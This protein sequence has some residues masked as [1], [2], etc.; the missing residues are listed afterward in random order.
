MGRYGKAQQL[1]AI[2]NKQE[3]YNQYWLILFAYLSLLI[4]KASKN[5]YKS[6]LKLKKKT[7]ENSRKIRAYLEEH[8]TD[9]YIQAWKEACKIMGKHIP[10]PSEDEI[11]N[12][13]NETWVGSFNFKQ[14][15]ARNTNNFLNKLKDLDKDEKLSDEERLVLK[16][17]LVK[18]YRYTVYR[19]TRTETARIINTASLRAYQEAGVNYVEW[20]TADDEKVCPICGARER[21]VYQVSL[22]PNC[23]DHPNCRCV[24]IPY[25]YYGGLD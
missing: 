13:V 12:I 7:L 25:K 19:L 10:L 9:T 20:V 1:W 23:P 15:Q 24:L 21:K 2:Y 4:I 5:K 3:K 14:R 22:A 8:L 17:K 16:K 18:S 11:N 6:N